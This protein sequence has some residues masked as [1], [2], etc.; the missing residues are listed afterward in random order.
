MPDPADTAVTT[1]DGPSKT[2]TDTR[3][4]HTVDTITEEQLADLYDKL[5]AAEWAGSLWY[6]R[7]EKARRRADRAEAELDR[8][9]DAESALEARVRE[10]EQLLAESDAETAELADHSDRTCEAVAARDQ[11]EATI[12]RVQQAC[13]DLPYEH[14]R[15]ILTAL[16][17]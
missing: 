3:P 16:N 4:R 15:R 11:A 1:T 8:L 5:D 12:E 2:P 14:A 17:G 10:L 7:A 9:H 13:H 6:R